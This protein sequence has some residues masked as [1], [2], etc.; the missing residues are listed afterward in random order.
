MTL[1]RSGFDAHPRHVGAGHVGNEALA[2]AH[3]VEVGHHRSRHDLVGIIHFRADVTLGRAYPV[4]VLEMS[5]R[6]IRGRI[7]GC[8][9]DSFNTSEGRLSSFSGS[10]EEEA[11][12]KELRKRQLLMETLFS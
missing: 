12:P 10:D 8:D 11:F 2:V 7:S 4:V 5:R 1:P 9:Y 6:D 3:Q